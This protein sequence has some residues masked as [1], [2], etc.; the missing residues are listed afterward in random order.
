MR[1]IFPF[2]FSPEA[3]VGS[4]YGQRPPLA[5]FMRLPYTGRQSQRENMLPHLVHDL[6]VAGIGD[7]DPAGHAVDAHTIAAARHR[8]AIIQFIFKISYCLQLSISFCSFASLY[9]NKK[10]QTQDHFVTSCNNTLAYNLCWIP[11]SLIP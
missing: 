4:A 1:T 11:R 10:N 3:R 9:Y 7:D 2:Q 8:V 5:I 6:V